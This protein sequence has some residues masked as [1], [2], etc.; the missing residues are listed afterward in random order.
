MALDEPLAHWTSLRVGGPADALVR[1][2]TREELVRVCGFCRAHA[3]PVAILGGGFNSLVR[4]GGLRGVVVRLAGLREVALAGEGLVRAE[5]GVTHSQLTRFCAEQGRSGLE[6]A[7]GIPGTV[8]G[9]IAMNAGVHGREMKDR[10]TSLELFDPALGA[11]ASRARE[12]LVFRYRATELPPGAV[13][14]SATF[15]TEQA[16]PEEIRERQKALLAQRRATQPVDQPSCG[17]VFKN[18]P[19][20]YAGRLIEAAGL[21]G[22]RE[23]NAAISELHANFIVNLG[24]A[25]AADVLRLIERARAEV[26]A[27]FGVALETEVRVEGEAS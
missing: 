18:P 27:R 11:I 9:W 22:T 25:S 4:D 2:D 12:Q 1:V 23:G 16:K 13:V 3:L 26:S 21:K 15:R 5:A 20:D 19:G 8:G 14:V 7:V 24:G 17:S 10:V 6:F